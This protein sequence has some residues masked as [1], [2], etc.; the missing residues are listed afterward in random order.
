MGSGA[1]LANEEGGA[2]RIMAASLDLHKSSGAALTTLMSTYRPKMCYFCVL[3][4][5][6]R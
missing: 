5:M 6:G 4:T 3:I 1:L 2:D